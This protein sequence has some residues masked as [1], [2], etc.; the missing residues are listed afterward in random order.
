MVDVRNKPCEVEASE[1]GSNLQ[2]NDRDTAIIY[3]GGA[4]YF[5]IV[6]F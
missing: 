3:K 6:V 5:Y 4:E 1:Q 2:A